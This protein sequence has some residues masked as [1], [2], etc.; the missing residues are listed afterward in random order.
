ME[1]EEEEEE[2][3]TGMRAGA[4][5]CAGDLKKNKKREKK[6]KNIRA[7]SRTLVPLGRMRSVC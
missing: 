1:E 6:E 5:F 3:E 2:E 4:D 7:G